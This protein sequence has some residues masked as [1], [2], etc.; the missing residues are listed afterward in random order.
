MIASHAFTESTLELTSF[1]GQYIPPQGILSHFLNCST[2]PF[3]MVPRQA[4]KLLSR[5]PRNLQSQLTLE[6][7]EASLHNLFFLWSYGVTEPSALN[8]HSALIAAHINKISPSKA[9]LL[10]I[11]FGIT[12]RRR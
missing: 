11:S 1:D 9:Q 10:Q 4:P 6:L 8:D 7:P 12:T 2:Q 5:F 3:L